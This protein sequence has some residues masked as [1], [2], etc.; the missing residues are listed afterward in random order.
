MKF[1]GSVTCLRIPAFAARRS[2]SSM[3]MRFQV[4]WTRIFDPSV[5]SRLTVLMWHAR[6]RVGT[7]RR[8]IKIPKHMAHRDGEPYFLIL[9]R[10]NAAH[11]LLEA[12]A[13]HR[14]LEKFTPQKDR[15]YRQRHSDDRVS[16]GGERRLERDM[17]LGTAA[18]R[19]QMHLRQA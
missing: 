11:R 9:V 15:C 13:S 7:E 3:V 14:H 12:D 18:A 4:H 8:L 1:N 10:V 2:S 19:G 17:H 16:G 6:R 5:V